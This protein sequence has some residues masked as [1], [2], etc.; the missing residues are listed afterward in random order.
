LFTYGKV[1]IAVAKNAGECLESKESKVGAFTT[2][3]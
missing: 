3:D 2:W 1:L